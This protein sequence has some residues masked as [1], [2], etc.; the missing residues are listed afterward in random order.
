[1]QSTNVLV[2]GGGPGGYV[3]AI[4]TAQAGIPTLLVGRDRPGGTSLNIG[5]IPSKALIHAANEFHRL[6]GQQLTRL[7]ITPGT[8]ALVLRQLHPWKQS[9]VDQLT[10]G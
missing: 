3:T 10:G 7:R 8:P 5:C 4:R 6:S 1:M 2:L 9:V